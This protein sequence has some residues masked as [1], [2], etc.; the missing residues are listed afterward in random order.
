MPIAR[1]VMQQMDALAES[2]ASTIEDYA[3]ND[4]CNENDKNHVL[5]WASQ[6]DEDDRLF[7]LEQTDLLLKR[8]YFTKDKFEKILDKAIKKTASKILRD[9]SFLDVQ[10]DGKSQSDMLEILNS[11]C[12]I[13]TAFQLTLIITQRIDSFIR[14]MLF[15][16]VIEFV[17]ILKSG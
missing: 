6:F 4:F 13:L 16:L 3:N 11:S 14:M 5:K 7:I 1:E 12:L 10:L 2:I 8:Q 9:T 17:E 15:S